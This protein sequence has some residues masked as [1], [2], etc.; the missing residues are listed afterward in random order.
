[1]NTG[2]IDGSS[3]VVVGPVIVDQAAYLNVNYEYSFVSVVNGQVLYP[4]SSKVG[5]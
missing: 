2:V 1:M 5:Y 4:F 3:Y